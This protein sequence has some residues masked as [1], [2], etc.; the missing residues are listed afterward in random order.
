MQSNIILFAITS[1]LGFCLS[2]PTSIEHSLVARDASSDCDGGTYSGGY[3]DGS[4]T[5]VNSDSVTHPYKF[6]LIRKCWKDY[7]IVEQSIWSA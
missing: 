6:P 7:F 5:Y 1:F 2:S 3:S 4:G